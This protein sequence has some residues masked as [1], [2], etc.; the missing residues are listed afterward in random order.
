MIPCLTGGR[1]G[2]AEKAAGAL[3][4]TTMEGDCMVI[5]ICYPYPFLMTG[6][7]E[8]TPYV[9]TFVWT[10]RGMYAFME[11]DFNDWSCCDSRGIPG[12][13]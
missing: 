6:R 4:A 10:C 3:N 12:T 8:L 11:G 7:K 1:L 5:C 9:F 2:P 13:S